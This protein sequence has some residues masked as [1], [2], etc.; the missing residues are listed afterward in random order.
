MLQEHDTL[1]LGPT[2]R[3]NQRTLYKRV[4]VCL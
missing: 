4:T 3:L 1:H 2:L